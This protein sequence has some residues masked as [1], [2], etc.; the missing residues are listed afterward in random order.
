MGTT[1]HRFKLDIP[2]KGED[3]LGF[4]FVELLYTDIFFIIKNYPMICTSTQI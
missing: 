2:I 3:K 4:F 1:G